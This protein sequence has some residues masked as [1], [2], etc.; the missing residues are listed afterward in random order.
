MPKINVEH[1]AIKLQSATA[2]FLL[3][4]KSVDLNIKANDIKYYTDGVKTEEDKS[5]AS[6]TL[7]IVA[8]SLPQAEYCSMFGHTVEETTEEVVCKGGDAS[9]P[10][11]AG[12][13]GTNVKGGVKS[14]R[15]IW[16]VNVTF[17]EPSDA[18]KCKEGTMSYQDGATLEGSVDLDSND[19][20]KREKTFPTKA[21]A[22]TWL[23]AKAG[24]TD[25][26][27]TDDTSGGGDESGT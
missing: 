1:V 19:E 8:G 5:F 26:G 23:N 4:S 15:A 3:D 24:I 11:G 13:I 12:F 7:K 18:Y 25:T 20:W 17:A 2:G 22:I 16:L 21:E 10:C 6:G 9:A 14:Y 27:E